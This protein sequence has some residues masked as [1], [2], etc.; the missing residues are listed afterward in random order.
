[1]FTRESLYAKQLVVPVRTLLET[2]KVFTAAVATSKLVKMPVG[3]WVGGWAGSWGGPPSAARVPQQH[4]KLLV[5]GTARP[6]ARHQ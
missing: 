1:M 3:G 5:A 6:A 2:F 4:A